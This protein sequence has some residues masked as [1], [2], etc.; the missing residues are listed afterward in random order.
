MSLTEIGIGIHRH[1]V[2]TEVADHIASLENKVKELKN[3]EEALRFSVAKHKQYS[4]ELQEEINLLK[5][6]KPSPPPK[7]DNCGENVLHGT[8]H[9]DYGDS[10]YRCHKKG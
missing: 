4:D 9:F 10:K 8:E 5:G 6:F 1:V 2:P 7:C 3:I